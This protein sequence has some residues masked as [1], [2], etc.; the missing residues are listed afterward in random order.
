MNCQA[1]PNCVFA[2]PRGSESG[3]LT[4]KALEISRRQLLSRFMNLIPR[5]QI[6]A[7]K[8]A[9]AGTTRQASLIFL[10]LGLVAVSGCNPSSNPSATENP[11]PTQRSQDEL[12]AEFNASQ[13]VLFLAKS[14]TELAKMKSSPQAALTPLDNGLKVTS[15]GDDPQLI[16]PPFAEGKQFILQ[17]V[18]QSPV[19]DSA[20]LFFLLQGQSSYLEGQSYSL[21][22]KPG[23]NVIYFRLDSPSLIDPLRFDPAVHPGNYTIESITARAIPNSA[24]P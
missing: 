12:A 18:I 16:L 15:S 10:T 2:H 23:K 21:P 11:P 1:A 4:K 22:L 14:G 24:T 20:Q 7:V 8:W 13:K 5:I 6:E 3:Q 19:D 17:V 9:T